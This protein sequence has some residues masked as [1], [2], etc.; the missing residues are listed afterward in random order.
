MLCEQ[1][2]YVEPEVICPLAD[3]PVTRVT[4]VRHLVLEDIITARRISIL[5]EHHSS[6][7]TSCSVRTEI[8]L[9]MF[10]GQ[11]R[12]ENT[13]SLRWRHVTPPPRKH[14]HAPERNSCLLVQSCAAERKPSAG[15]SL[16]CRPFQRALL[17]CPNVIECSSQ[18]PAGDH[19]GNLS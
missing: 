15:C 7:C 6:P 14:P 4:D 10:F 1:N 17:C 2:I 11:N 12:L 19:S 9:V 16:G 3:I 13:G 8:K 18:A 5:I